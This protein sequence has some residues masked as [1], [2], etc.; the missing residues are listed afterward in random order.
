M[1]SREERG[2]D[3]RP[4]FTLNDIVNNV[5][6]DDYDFYHPPIP[7]PPQSPQSPQPDLLHSSTS[8]TP[9]SPPT[10]VGDPVTDSEANNED[11][12]QTESESDQDSEPDSDRRSNMSDDGYDDNG[13]APDEY[14]PP[15]PEYDE[16]EE[17]YQDDV[18]PEHEGAGNN[19][20]GSNAA[21]DANGL[22]DEQKTVGFDNDG[23]PVN[24]SSQ[25]VQD[26]KIPK[27]KRLTTPYMTKYERARVLGVRAQ[28]ISYVFP[29]APQSTPALPK[30][31]EK[32]RALSCCCGLINGASTLFSN[33]TPVLVDLEGETDPLQIAIKELRE[34]K[35][36]LIIRR[37]YP[38]GWYEDWTCEELL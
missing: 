5:M 27:E 21:K 22:T 2:D 18:E 23:N 37:Y 1:A 36:P 30:K 12:P 6:L 15:E 28:Q 26:K 11:E 13:Y 31:S 34:K 16:P 19:A 10:L 24:K 25:P 9:S 14:D 7:Q 8:P 32:C 33:N 29:I 4:N 17:P 20:N 38:D 35:M 3:D